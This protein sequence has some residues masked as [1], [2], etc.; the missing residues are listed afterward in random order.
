MEDGGLGLVLSRKQWERV[1]LARGGEVIG[2]VAVTAIRGDRV[3]LAFKF[4]D[5]IT[6]HREE[7]WKDVCA[8]R[9]GLPVPSRTMQEGTEC[10]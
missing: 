2:Y 10:D 8:Q 5:D 3:R 6:I 4:G 7:V 1:V 9:A